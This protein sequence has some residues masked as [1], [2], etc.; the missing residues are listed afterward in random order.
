V[1]VQ[2]PTYTK[3]DGIKATVPDKETS[4]TLHHIR[5]LHYQREHL[6]KTIHA[7]IKESTAFHQI[8][9]PDFSRKARQSESRKP[10]QPSPVR[11]PEQREREREGGKKRHESQPTIRGPR[12]SA[13]PMHLARGP[14]P[15]TR[16]GTSSSTM[17]DGTRND[18]KGRGQAGGMRGFAARLEN[19][20]LEISLSLSLSLHEDRISST[21]PLAP[22]SSQG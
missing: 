21:G 9:L 2:S 11:C 1:T 10:A 19:H 14:R 7:L 15:G 3:R 13:P 20:P 17:R 6:S 5:P 22:S 8:T 18:N 12:P 16:P 4:Q